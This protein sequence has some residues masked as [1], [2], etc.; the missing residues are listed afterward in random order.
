MTRFQETHNYEK[1]NYENIEK[2]KKET[3]ILNESDKEINLNNKEKIITQKKQ[4]INDES[5]TDV[6]ISEDSKISSIEARDLLIGLREDIRRIYPDIPREH[7]ILRKN[8]L[9]CLY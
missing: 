6:L 3:E 1:N 4:D 8:M 2:N 5:N 9:I 7:G